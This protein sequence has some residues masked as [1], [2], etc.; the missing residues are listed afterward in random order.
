MGLYKW[1]FHGNERLYDVG[2]RK[3]GTL[4]NPRGY[5]EDVVRQAVIAADERAH[6][7]RSE[8][9]KKAAQTRKERQG[10]EVYRA[11]QAIIEGRNFQPRNSCRICGKG[12]SDAPSIARGI[13]SDCW[14]HVLAALSTLKAKAS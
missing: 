5:A 12:V 4:H 14:Q 10:R 3:D 1:V 13:G 6:K 8:A 7:A 11:A 9:A 2:I